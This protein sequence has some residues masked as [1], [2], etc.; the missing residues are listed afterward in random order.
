MR[1]YQ[2]LD[3]ASVQNHILRL[4]TAENNPEQPWL[5]MSR[6][7]AFLSLS[8]SFG[9]L[10]IALRLN[11][12]NFTKRLQQLHPVPGLATTRQVGTANSYIALGLT[13]NQHLVM[14]PTIV[15]D[16]SGRISFNLLATTPVYRAML[17][18]LGVKI[19]P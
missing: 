1:N 4:R 14:I 9:P 10:E 15:T 13:D 19:D 3:S 5:S 11:Y 18:W 8:T 2:V 17:D 12:D 7:G 6:E 16:A